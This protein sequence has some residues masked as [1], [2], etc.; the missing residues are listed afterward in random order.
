MKLGELAQADGCGDGFYA[1]RVVPYA[2]YRGFMSGVLG[3]SASTRL[4]FQWRL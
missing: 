1:K 3:E 4:M 2:G